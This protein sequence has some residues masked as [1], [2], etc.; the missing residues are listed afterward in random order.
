MLALFLPVMALLQLPLEAAL[1]PLATV[2]ILLNPFRELSTLYL[3]T[4]VAA[5]IAD[6]KQP[7]T[8][9]VESEPDGLAPAN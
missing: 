2:D 8:P 7:A 5:A 4:A 9:N 3:G 6:R 1:I